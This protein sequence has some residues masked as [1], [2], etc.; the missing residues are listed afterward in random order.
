MQTWFS[1]VQAQV[2]WNQFKFFIFRNVCRQFISAHVNSY[3][4]SFILNNEHKP[5]NTN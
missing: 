4:M 3:Q 1:P 2:N 5:N